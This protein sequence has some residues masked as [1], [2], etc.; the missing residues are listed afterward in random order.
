MKELMIDFPPIVLNKEVKNSKN[1]SLHKDGIFMAI[2]KG[3]KFFIW[4][5]KYKGKSISII[6][7]KRNKKVETLERMLKESKNVCNTQ[8]NDIKVKTETIDNLTRVKNEQTNEIQVLNE[9]IKK[10]S[11]EL[12]ETINK[13]MLREKELHKKKLKLTK[14]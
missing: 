14:I 5:T 9:I 10:K 12:K 11:K 6:I 8:Q 4:F 13:N 3:E 7:N 2:P 1:M